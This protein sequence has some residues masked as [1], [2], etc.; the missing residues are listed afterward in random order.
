MLQSPQNAPNLK[1]ALPAQ[2]A[3]ICMGG[4]I[5]VPNSKK[6]TNYYELM[7][8]KD[9][10]NEEGRKKF[11]TKVIGSKFVK[12][13]L[14]R[15]FKHADREGDCFGDVEKRK[16]KKQKTAAYTTTLSHPDTILIPG[17]MHKR[18]INSHAASMQSLGRCDNSGDGS[19]SDDGSHYEIDDSAFVEWDTF[20][21]F[22]PAPPPCPHLPALPTDIHSIQFQ[23]GIPD[24]FA[25]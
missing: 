2:T 7:Y 6:G 21:S 13:H 25:G 1:G 10:H 24:I 22:V 11:T 8:N 12:D 23:I 16:E 18:N 17:I 4:V 20:D 3:Y 15:A 19:T 9:H 14:K 5:S